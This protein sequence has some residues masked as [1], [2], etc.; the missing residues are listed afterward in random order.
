MTFGAFTPRG[1]SA[2]IGARRTDAA[3]PDAYRPALPMSAAPTHAPAA[4]SALWRTAEARLRESV[5]AHSHAVFTTSLG[6]ED[7]VVLD[8]ICRAALPVEI[9]TLDTGRLPEA[10]HALLDA[11]R[12]RYRRPIRT[13]HPDAAALEAFVAAE[14]TNPFYRSVELRKACCAIRKVEPLK[15]ALAGRA[16]WI[17]GLR[18]AQAVTRGALEPLAFD[19]EHG[20]H[21][22]SPLVEWTSADVLGYVETHD[23]PVSAL[24]AQGYPSIGC[25]PCTR[26]VAPGEDE[27]AGRWWWE[28][29]QTK[30]C[31]L[32]VTA[33]GRIARAATAPPVAPA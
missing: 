27:R 28:S 12:E 20:L 4:R 1:R 32:H 30:E 22:V 9:V 8:L 2:T 26:A 18:R 17:T 31:G 10:T 3:A 21:K 16:L 14:G 11:A 6:M 15:R 19:A 24:H 13:L 33:D 5:A 25:A 23:V 7:M 29:P